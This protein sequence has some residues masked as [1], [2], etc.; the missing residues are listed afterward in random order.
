MIKKSF[1]SKVEAFKYMKDKHIN[2]DRIIL[3]IE[4]INSYEIIYRK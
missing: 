2:F 1:N 4:K 3:L